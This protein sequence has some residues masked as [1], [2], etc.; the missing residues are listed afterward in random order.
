MLD[1]GNRDSGQ[2]KRKYPVWLTADQA[3]SIV[4][5][6]LF[7]TDVRGVCFADSRN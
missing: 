6:R 7:S 5:Q 3:E 4:P 1:Q 2:G